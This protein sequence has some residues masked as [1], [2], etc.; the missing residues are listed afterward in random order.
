[1]K[2]NVVDSFDQTCLVWIPIFLVNLLKLFDQRDVLGISKSLTDDVL[3][4]GH[5]QKV[6]RWLFGVWAFLNVLASHF[7]LM[8]AM[9]GQVFRWADSFN[10]MDD[11]CCATIIMTVASL[12]QQSFAMTCPLFAVNRDFIK[13]NF[14]LGIDEM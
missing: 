12:R 11:P 13:L 7:L 14:D 4:F 10:Q 8:T 5:V 3:L 1:M 2:L 9:D 6:V